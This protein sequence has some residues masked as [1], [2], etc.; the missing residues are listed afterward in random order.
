MKNLESNF[1]RPSTASNLLAGLMVVHLITFGDRIFSGF[2]PTWWHQVFG[3][4]ITGAYCYVWL[5][6]WEVLK[7]QNPSH[8]I[9]PFIPII[10][11]FL[12][13]NQVAYTILGIQLPM[14]VS[15]PIWILSMGVYLAFGCRVL[16]LPDPLFGLKVSYALSLIVVH[17]IDLVIYQVFFRFFFDLAADNYVYFTLV[18]GLLYL[19]NL[20]FMYQI[21]VRARDRKAQSKGNHLNDLIGTIGQDTNEG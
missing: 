2:L 5:T 14:W 13:Y 7:Q 10:I 8:R 21:L 19:V 9:G 15:T 16:V 12:V 17:V 18:S 4:I 3:I 11:A 6:F 20:V 1:L